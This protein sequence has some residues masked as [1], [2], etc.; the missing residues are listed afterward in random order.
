M[1]KMQEKAK[2]DI[3]SNLNESR[4]MNSGWILLMA[5]SFQTTM[6]HD[7]RKKLLEAVEAIHKSKIL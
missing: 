5:Y 4:Y 6:F 7:S 1:N 3:I 2:F